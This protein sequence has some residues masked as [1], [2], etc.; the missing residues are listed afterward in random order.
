MGIVD[1]D[2][3]VDVVCFWRNGNPPVKAH[4]LDRQGEELDVQEIPGRSMQIRHRIP[5]V[6]CDDAG[7]YGL[8]GTPP[9]LTLTVRLDN[10]RKEEQ[11]QWRL[12]LTNDVGTGS[13]E[14]DIGITGVLVIML[15]VKEIVTEHGKETSLQVVTGT[16]P[17]LTLTV[18]LDNVRKE[19]EGQWRL[20]LTNDV[21]TGQV[22]F[23]LSVEDGKYNEVQHL[24]LL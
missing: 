19:E 16:P 22:D 15:P 10:V 9:D 20:E 24:G 21:G 3:E 5:A 4:I 6:S 11:G 8:T 12:E 1:R 2:S 14:F 17:D 23:H 18:R 13:D 7:M